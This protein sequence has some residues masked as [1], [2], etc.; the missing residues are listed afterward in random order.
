VRASLELLAKGQEVGYV[1][2][3]GDLDFD[4]AGLTRAAHTDWWRITAEGFE[5]V[6]SQSD[7][8]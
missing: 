2:V 3:T 1:G 6:P 4:A 5:D 8:R 7:C